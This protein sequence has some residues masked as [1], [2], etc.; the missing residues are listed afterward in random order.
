MNPVAEEILELDE[1]WRSSVIIILAPSTP[2]YSVIGMQAYPETSAFIH[3]EICFHETAPNLQ[4][5]AG[6]Q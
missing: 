2:T 6:S 1:G 5:W 3:L 4:G